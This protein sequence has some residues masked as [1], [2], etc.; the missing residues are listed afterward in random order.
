MKR[1]SLLVISLLLVGTMALFLLLPGC[2][3]DKGKAKEYMEKGDETIEGLESTS[4]TLE[5]DID[6]LIN[7]LIAGESGAS[8][9]KSGADEV[10]SNID[11][12]VTE[13]K[14]AKAEYEKISGLKGVDDYEEYADLRIEA[15]DNAGVMMTK[16]KELL[17]NLQDL[18]QEGQPVDQT[19]LMTE[20]TKWSEE[21]QELVEEGVDLSE[22]AD[23]L[24]TD[25]N[26]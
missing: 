16:L 11:G 14:K 9:F 10:I 13:S 2:G 23:K 3:G 25:K 22:K 20:I 15:I 1:R 4:A 18:V 6:E 19:A 8:E 7:G 5:S 24:K 17:S 26:L 12:L 21:N